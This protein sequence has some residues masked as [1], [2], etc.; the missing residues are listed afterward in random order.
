[1]NK[2]ICFD[3]GGRKKRI[4]QKEKEMFPKDFF[5]GVTELQKQ[6]YDIIRMSSGIPY[7]GIIGIIN[8][9][10]ELSL[11][12]I[13]RLGIRKYLIT[14]L[15]RQ[16]SEAN[17]IISFTD[18]FSL[19]LGLFLKKKNN[20]VVGC[21]HS[22]SDLSSRSNPVFRN[23]S[24]RLISKSLDK[25]DH[26]AFFG[27]ADRDNA[28]KEYNLSISKTSIIKFGVDTN[29]WKPKTNSKETYFFSVGQDIN[30]DFQ[31][32]ID[33]KI[34]FP[35][36]IH[37][38]L[39]LKSR[40]NLINNVKI[41]KG[42][43][44]KEDLDDMGL[45][46]L[47][48]NA[49]AIIVPLKDVFQPSG[50]SVTLQAM[51]CAKPVVLSKTKGL[52]APDLL[53]D[54]YNCLLVRPGDKKQLTEAMEKLKNNPNLRKKIGL[55]ARLTVKKYFNLKVAGNSLKNIIKKIESKN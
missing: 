19:T 6:G 11:S 4:P 52:W 25:L 12:H 49:I 22:L 40:N 37:T 2:I 41:T 3:K 51:S 21:F 18:G 26:I 30:R 54:N 24:K 10:I 20:F 13:N 38:E 32:L 17:L 15:K 43:F 39:N 33:A 23:W 31:T 16:L 35:I 28:V 5:Y 48:Q 27:P 45:R 9:F 7:K 29:F 42:S 50:Y 34:N 55:Q 47:Y 14:C 1:M 46:Q 44:Y 36:H 53:I 8:R